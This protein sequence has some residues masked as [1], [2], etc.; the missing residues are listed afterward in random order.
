MIEVASKFP[1]FDLQ[2][3]HFTKL[4]LDFVR[5]KLELSVAG[6]NVVKDDLKEPRIYTMNSL[7]CLQEMC[8]LPSCKNV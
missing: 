6:Y 5:Q 4:N 1:L 2:N 7:C 8:Y 3:D